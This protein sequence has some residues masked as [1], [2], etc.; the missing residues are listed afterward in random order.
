MNVQTG[1]VNRHMPVHPSHSGR[2]AN[3]APPFSPNPQYRPSQ[4]NVEIIPSKSGQNVLSSGFTN[5]S[6]AVGQA[7]LKKLLLSTITFFTLFAIIALTKF[8]FDHTQFKASQTANFQS[9]VVSKATNITHTLDNQIAWIDTALGINGSSK[10]VVDFVARGQG[11][12]AAALIDQS[13]RILSATPN[14]GE[15][16]KQID[17]RNFPKG[18]VQVSSLISKDGTITP[19]VTRRVNEK[20]LIV[21]LTP[22]SLVGQQTPNMSI[23]LDGGR[24]I[25]GPPQMG[26][27]GTLKYYAL[28]PAKL[29]SL[30][31]SDTDGISAH[32]IN[33]EKVWISS[34]RVPNSFLTVIDTQSR[35]MSPSL[36]NNL[37]LFSLLFAGTAWLIWT[38]IRNMLGQI[39]EL[40]SQKSSEEVSQQRY[41]AALDGSR[42]GVWEI[43]LHHNQAYISQSL[44][45][46]LGLPVKEHTL[47]M[48]QFL[49]L[50]HSADRDKLLSLIKRAHVSGE[51]EIEVKSAHLPLSLACRGRPSVRGSDQAKVVIGMALDVTE[52]RG[53]QVRLQA[54]EARLVDAL[55]SMN[56]SFVIWDQLDRLVLWNNKFA[57]FFGLPASNL[58]QGLDYA[59]V[60]YHANNAIE[61]IYSLED[62]SGS[63]IQLKDGRWIRYL[64]THTVDGGRVSIGTEVTAIRTREQQLQV[65]QD[66]LHKTIN[67]LK[68]SQVRIVELAENYE[69]EKIRAEEANH[70]KSEFL[71]NM[72]HELRTPLNAINGFSDIM[73]K[74]MFGP[75]GDPRYKEYV[76][77]ILFSGQHLL[78]L[79]NDI[80]DMSKIEAG[81]MTLNTEALQMNDMINQV[82][83]IIRGRA[84][85]NRL[86]L[87]YDEVSLP[88]IE[89]DPRN[90]KQI[91]LNLTTN[92]IKFTPEG[93]VVTIA[94]EPKSAGLIIRVS[95]TG[96]GISEEDIQRLAQPF[97]QIDSQHSRKH[98]GTGLGLALS[99]SLVELHGGNFKIESVLGQ[100]TTVTFTLPNTPLVVKPVETSTEVGNEISRLAKDIADV[101]TVGEMGT[102]DNVS[103]IGAT[104]PP[105]QHT[106]F[107]PHQNS[108][109]QPSYKPEFINPAA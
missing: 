68:K 99:K 103:P 83:R 86:K 89:A 61:N 95:D 44:A 79:I 47:S 72:S 19:V 71:A 25:D 87:V 50:F 43:D 57:D 109:P 91:L 1:S 69:Q 36:I 75:L 67:V 101:L 15:P 14:A 56:D 62:G 18:G 78:S 54:A 23:V 73:K 70:S 22:N 96:I 24:V 58:Q 8:Y 28:T 107:V 66:A 2:Q 26:T 37:I 48:P 65:N 35:K 88:E 4:E 7:S 74:E 94:V 90:V 5:L 29:K 51:F 30:T 102:V 38:L 17:R 82:I 59:T 45:G 77:D 76:S 98:E 41:R 81:K 60:E 80:L 34:A 3:N 52:M 85:E 10:Q 40:R 39:S 32:K 20:F 12:V 6:K 13:G 63:E 16:L 53:A 106:E 108:T 105:A 49:G 27:D 104:Q 97:E 100:G 31:S 21:A 93:G 9:K 92:A 42:G 84:D 46:L 55:S 33:G 11:I 64:E